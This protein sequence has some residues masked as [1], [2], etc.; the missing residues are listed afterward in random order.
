MSSFYLYIL[1]S[2]FVAHDFHLSKT[3]VRYK[4]D[5]SAVQVSTHIFIDD[6]EMVLAEYGHADLELFTKRENPKADQFIYEYIQASLLIEVDG[7]PLEFEWVGK[8]I[9]EDLAA[10]WCYLEIPNVQI[11]EEMHLLNKVLHDVFDDQ[12]NVVSFQYNS[13]KKQHMFFSQGD[14]AKSLDL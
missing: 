9:S 13:N 4:E 12:K 5:I 1:L 6:L 11:R 2:A 8:E 14:K 7:R 10:V 3:E